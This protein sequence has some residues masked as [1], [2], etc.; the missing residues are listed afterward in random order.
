MIPNSTSNTNGCTPISSNCVIWQGPDIPCI[1]ICNGATV[2]DVVAMLAQEV[3]NAGE[4]FTNVIDDDRP[5]DGTRSNPL[6]Q[7]A[8][9]SSSRSARNS[10]S[11]DGIVQKCLATENG[12]NAESVQELLQWMVDKM[13]STNGSGG[14]SR[15]AEDVCE[16][17]KSCTL[18]LPDCAKY[19]RGGSAGADGEIVGGTE[20][21]EE[22]LYD[23]LTNSGWIITMGNYICGLRS[24]I[25]SLQ[26][27]VNNH[28]RRI[29]ALERGTSV[30]TNTV[31]QIRIDNNGN[32][33]AVPRKTT[34]VNANGAEEIISKYLRPGKITAGGLALLVEKMS[35][36]LQRVTGNP[37]ELR[38]AIGYAQQGLSASD[39]LNGA[40]KMSD[41]QG[42]IQNVRTVAQSL[43]NLWI[44]ANDMRAAVSDLKAAAT[45]STCKDIKFSCNASIVR[46]TTGSWKHLA[47]DFAGCDIPSAYRDS[48][49]GNQTKITISDASLNSRVYYANVSGKY[50]NS[51]PFIISSVPGVDYLTSNLVVKV[52]FSVSDESHECAETQTINVNNSQQ[53]PSLA[54]STTTENSISYA[55]NYIG[56]VPGGDAKININL[57][58]SLGSTIQTKVYSTWSGGISGSFTSL[59]EATTYGLQI[60]MIDKNGVSKNC[61][62]DTLQTSAPSC[63]STHILNTAY[64]SDIT[65]QQTGSNSITIATYDD[66]LNIYKWTATFNDANT[67]IVIKSTITTA[68][69]VSW[70]HAGEFVSKNPTEAIKC[71]TV[72]YTATG[73]TTAMADSGW[74]YVGAISGPTGSVFYA[75]ALIN[76]IT[77]DVVEVVFCCKC[78]Q[79]TLVPEPEYGVFYC[80]TGGTT[81]CK[82]DI[83]GYAL[84]TTKQPEW[85]IVNQPANG[86]V[87]YD[88]SASSPIQGCFT[89]S[90]SGGAWSSDSFTVKYYNK[91]GTTST[92]IVPIHK[93]EPLGLTDDH[94]AVFVDTSKFTFAEANKIKTTFNTITTSLR[95][96]C[97]WNGSISYIPI[98]NA[99]ATNEEPG[100]YIKHLKGL[101]DS[102]GGAGSYSITIATGATTWDVWKSLPGYFSASSGSYPSSFTVFSFTNQTNTNG[103]YGANALAKGWATPTQ[104]TGGTH[105][106]VN[107]A[108]YKEDY[109]ALLDIINGTANSKWAADF[110]TKAAT[111]WKPGSIPFK[112][113]HIVINMV[114]DSI[115]ETSAAALQML[116]AQTGDLMPARNFYGAKIGGVQF[117]VDLSSYLLSGKAPASS[118]P[119]TGNDS[120]SPDA[121]PIVG[122]MNYNYM[123]HM[124]FENGIDWSSSNTHLKAAIMGMINTTEGSSLGCPINSSAPFMGP[125]AA[126]F[127]SSATNAAGAC[128]AAATGT[129]QI[130]NS[131]GTIFDAT[132]KAYSTESG[133]TWSQSQYELTNGT[134]YAV[135]PGTSGVSMVAQYST[136]APYWTGQTTCP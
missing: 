128:T 120:G 51:D 126:L 66:T 21:T 49:K 7:P 79:I 93:A 11:I 122:L 41:I 124:Y 46:E 25:T 13:C 60:Q 27:Q 19:M 26:N 62:I 87:T 85:E 32:P 100:D 16:F 23:S 33:I 121:K 134:W 12:R 108:G 14:T 55:Y 38:S 99:S 43:Q 6:V 130:W 86:T 20:V 9:M 44:T 74:K 84:N 29:T 118:N 111:P 22:V 40:G 72:N 114:S 63:T 136:T 78:N 75:Y 91:C 70:S 52:E 24:S 67:P 59:Q 56:L 82:I 71:G 113:R 8:G 89:Y 5:D 36:D 58:N 125:A 115:G 48:G 73:M 69:T 107:N 42:F 92:L 101:V 116:G 133:A 112:Y 30:G 15:S 102:Q 123:F 77:H 39:K 2:S 68:P 132:V 34:N 129:I 83:V 110:Q 98:I 3:C 90:N 28:E 57:L 37:V 54:S 96:S 105:A 4:A 104:P 94:I 106:H 97:G 131:T 103:N 50:Q 1:N 64:S 119:Y 80:N 127:G 47:L 53:C 35:W 31:S 45:S 117:P 76:S 17:A 109:S 135:K 18:P 81:T 88:A 10:I 61:P 65:D 95:A